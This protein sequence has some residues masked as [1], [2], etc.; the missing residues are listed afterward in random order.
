MSVKT[1]N[2]TIQATLRILY[3]IKLGTLAAALMMLLFSNA[4]F[5]DNIGS[6]WL[7][8]DKKEL[9]KLNAETGT[10]D[11]TLAI[12]DKRI[13]HIAVDDKQS[14]VWLASE[15]GSLYEY[16]YNGTLLQTLDIRE[17]LASQIQEN[18]ESNLS[19]FKS[20][21]KK[22]FERYSKNR[23]ENHKRHK[24]DVDAL[25]VDKRD[26]SI[27]VGLENKMLKLSANGELLL[28]LPSKR[29]IDALALDVAQSR[30]WLST[31]KSVYSINTE[32][33]ETVTTLTLPL[34]YPNGDNDDDDEDDDKKYKKKTIEVNHIEFD[35]HLGQLWLTS[36]YRLLRFDREGV[37]VFDQK[38]QDINTANDRER[39]DDDDDDDD[40]SKKHK[41]DKKYKKHKKSKKYK[42][43]RPRITYLKDLKTVK[44]DGLGNVWLTTEKYVYRVNK[45]GVVTL[46]IKPKSKYHHHDHHKKMLANVNDHSLWLINKK[47]VTHILPDGTQIPVAHG[48]KNVEASA[49]NGDIN[50]P[51]LMLVSPVENGLISRKPEI[52]L[53]FTEVGVG[54]DIAS[55]N[56]KVNDA[57]VSVSCSGDSIQTICIPGNDILSETVTLTLS[58]NDRALNQSNTVSATVKLDSDGDGVP[59]LR[60]TYPEDPTRWRLAAVTGIQVALET[61]TVKLDW[62]QHIDPPKTKGYVI[63][64]TEFGQQETKVTPEPITTLEFIDSNVNNGTGYSYRIVAIDTRDYEGEPGVLH[65]F[66][67]AYNDTVVT[68]FS[69][70]REK[71][72]GLLNWTEV[73]GKRYQLYRD[74]STATSTPVIQLP[75]ASSTYLDHNPLWNL[76]YYYRISTLADFVDVFT[77]QAVVVEG[78]LSAPIELPPLPPLGLN[79]YDSHTIADN[80]FELTLLDPDTMSITGKYTE[81]VGTVSITATAADATSI[82]QD[83]S[84]NKFNLLLPVAKGLNWTVSVSELTVANRTTT[85]NLILKEDKEAPVITIDGDANRSVDTE[86]ILITGTAVDIGIGIK[87]VYLTNN[88]FSGEE[89]GSILSGDN[90]SA[91]I[92]LESGEN[93]VTVTATDRMGN[94]SS[95]QVTVTLRATVLPKIS[96]LTPQTGSVFYDNAITVTGEVYTS[97]AADSIKITLGNQQVFPTQSSSLD[98]YS[99]SF[100][101]VR[102]NEGYNPLNVRV[103]TPAGSAEST[104]IVK[105]SSTPPEPEVTPAP[106]INLTSPRETTFLN[107]TSIIIS[108]DINSQAGISSVTVDGQLVSSSVTIA[109]QPVTLIGQT[110]NYKTFQYEYSLI[111]VEG[112]VS[113]DIV[114]T[115]SLNQVTTKTLKVSNDTLPPVITI[116]TPGIVLS[117]LVNSTNEMPYKLQGTVTDINLTGFSINGT[118]VSLLPGTTAGSY[119]FAVDLNLPTRAAQIVALEA[120]DT[121]GNRSSQELI[122]DVTLPV[123][124]EIISPRDKAEIASNTSGTNIDV[125]ARLTGM[126]ADYTANLV[127]DADAAVAM[128]MDGNVANLGIQTPLNSGEHNITIQILDA[129]QQ[130]ISSRSVSVNLKNIENLPLAVERTEPANDEQGVD[131]NERINVYFNQAIDPALLQIQVHETVHGKTYDLSSQ[132]AKGMGEISLPGL[133]E[134]HRDMESITGTL[135]QYP[136]NRY[137]TFNP[138]NL[139]NYDG[140][141]YVTVNYDGQELSRFNFKVKPVPTIISGMVR[142]QLGEAI[143]GLEVSIPEFKLSVLTDEKGNFSLHSK[144]A[145]KPLKGGRYSIIYNPDMGKAI[146][147][148]ATNEVSIQLG[149]VNITSTQIV[150]LLNSA[151]PFTYVKTGQ[152]PAL[153]AN[154]NMELDLSDATLT[155]PNGRNAGNLHIQFTSV[156]ELAFGTMKEATP[157]WMYAV[158]PA[159]IEVSGSVGVK[160][161]MPILFGSHDYVPPN[162]TLVVML[163]FSKNSRMIEPVGVGRIEDNVVTSVN[164]LSMQTMDYFGYAMVNTEHQPILQRFATGE[165]GSIELFKSELVQAISK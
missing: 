157:Y 71:V 76:A 69:A 13:K 53:T 86:S 134:I 112:Q 73:Q 89:F 81:A 107:A 104:T 40:K 102:L 153:L 105:Y 144:K 79:I 155:F 65:N 80:T 126:E 120:W 41:N 47:Y 128:N 6:L 129:S 131:P 17:I 67:V 30:L 57:D 165:T 98:T 101:N 77:D 83:R 36:K 127:F 37:L 74:E 106:F 142:D 33:G 62:A 156:Q 160:I 63:Y 31:E 161:Q 18:N 45:D 88:R 152:N 7:T 130:V 12:S 56:L 136:G 21:V 114:A 139:Y 22:I 97:Q 20:W 119:E 146:Y 85:V 100:S 148:T 19:R 15:R 50:A 162:G 118:T 90:F 9:V 164:K 75:E 58:L 43:R 150:T 24:I 147:G 59:D 38:V 125:V 64:R 122:F 124:I 137:S 145:G 51:V 140:T 11:L 143:E 49:I 29:D 158:Q 93:V 154:G 96:I 28:N 117:D 133:I 32:T 46:K 87:D 109:G 54:V 138:A 91:E 39:H 35:Q 26:G 3:Q 1:I 116:T 95:A 8:S 52:K 110:A 135:S 72:A 60:D 78:P 92:P 123:E 4:S 70:V 132:E 111:G 94:Q 99:Y 25:I 42:Q 151:I 66:F 108:G 103:V 2:S 44:T 68:G 27:W 16:D 163:G 121:A 84:D 159:G 14:K 10:V 61:K 5:A 34:K 82:T 23:K 48:L 141:I 115:D 113:I 149:N 55:I